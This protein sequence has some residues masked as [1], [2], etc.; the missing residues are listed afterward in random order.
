MKKIVLLT[1]MIISFLV[2]NAQER[3]VTGK[4]TDQQENTPLPGVSVLIQGTTTGTITDGDGRY[5]IE[6]SDDDVLSF[7]YVG[8]VNEE[9]AVGNQSV[10]NMAM[11]PDIQQLNEVVVIGYGKRDK[12]D[13]TGSLSN[14]RSD[15]IEDSK[16]MSPELAMQGRMPGVF[17]N[18][19]GG[20]PNARPE[21]R[22]RG[23]STINDASPLYVVDGVPI[24]EFGQGVDNGQVSDLRGGQNIFN[25]I[26]PGDIEQI[27]VLKDASAAAI[28][29]SRAANGVILITTKKGEE[30][31]PKVEFNASRGVQNIPETYDM[32]NTE[33]YTQIYQE[34][35]DNDY[36]YKTQQAPSPDP[37]ALYAWDNP[38]APYYNLF[39]P[40]STNPDYPYRG[41]DDTYDWQTP[42]LNKNAVIEDYSVRVSGGSESTTYYLGTG[43]SKT[44]SPLINNFNERY[45]LSTNIDSKISKVFEV[46]F[47]G[48]FSYLNAEDNINNLDLAEHSRIIPWQPI[49]NSN[50]PTGYMRTVDVEFEDNPGFDLTLNNPG[51][52]RLM[53]SQLK[54]WGEAAHTNTFAMTELKDNRYEM[55]KNFGKAYLQINPFKGLSVKGSLAIDYTNNTRTRPENTI[56]AVRFDSQPDNP[57]GADGNMVGSVNRRITKTINIVSDLTVNYDKRFGNHKFDLL[58]NA[59]SQRFS[60]QYHG[61]SSPRPDNDLPYDLVGG[62][63]TRWTNGSEG[64][65]EKTLIGYVGRLSYSYLDKYYLDVSVRRDGSS[66]FAPGHRWGT[67]PA[68]SAAWRLSSEDFVANALPYFDDLKLRVGYGTI[69]NSFSNGVG[70]SNFAYLSSI[71]TTPNYTLGTTPNGAGTRYM[72]SYINNFPNASLTW[73]KATTFNAGIDGALLDERLSFTIEYYNKLTD[74]I[75]QAGNLPLNTGYL[76][77]TLLNIASVRNSG[78]ELQLGYTHSFGDLTLDFNGNLTTVKNEIESLYDDNAVIFGNY[79]HEVGHSI[80]DIYGYRVGGIYQNVQQITADTTIHADLS[81]ANPQPGDMYFQD[82]YG[83]PEANSGDLKSY[84]PDSVVNAY[85]RDHIGSTIPGFYYGFNLSAQYKGLDLSVFFQGVGDVEKVNGVRRAGESLGIGGG[86]YWTSALNRWTEENPSTTMP[87]AI[88]GDPHNNNR[89]SSRWVESAAYMRLKNVELGFTLPPSVLESLKV[90]SNFRIYVSGTNLFTMTNWT[91]LDPENDQLPP[92][93]IYSVGLSAIF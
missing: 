67:F 51:P 5:T 10:I 18:S 73:E 2:A 44:E 78:F 36:L 30:G 93:R 72:G 47:L 85:D 28:Y 21:V 68:A 82:L 29:G 79:I 14:I 71:S 6:V 8:Y 23:V 55:L 16:S 38:S 12:K 56:D 80:K 75:I 86:N 60:W 59:N 25:L 90:M 48:R 1:S 87:R 19:T 62:V 39:N 32:M 13:L 35:F 24:M 77:P 41:N 17:V 22:I 52:A 50:D 63:D 61:L 57:Y 65:D 43:Y 53:T 66:Q 15:D 84:S 54:P 45:S 92:A 7:T 3:T 33:Q 70:Y 27:S 26:N 64:I 37:A 88:G 58:L 89:F 83:S 11:V 91:G 69:G 76:A 49:Y 46:G 20:N 4:V 31:A 81:G 42:L 40:N 74:G 34:M 9:I